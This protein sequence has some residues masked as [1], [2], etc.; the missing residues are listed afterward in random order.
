MSQQLHLFVSPLKKKNKKKIKLGAFP[1]QLE[2]TQ[3]E[4]S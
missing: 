4:S 1:Q 3:V 2:M